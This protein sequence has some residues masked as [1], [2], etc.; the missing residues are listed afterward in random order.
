MSHIPYFDPEDVISH[1]VVEQPEAVN[2]R[3]AARRIVLQVLYE[4]DST[5]HPVG[6]VIDSQLIYHSLPQRMWTYIQEMVVGILEHHER[7]DRVIQHFAP[8][9]PL[10]Q[11]A[12]IDRNILRIAIYEFA[13]VKRTPVK[14][15]IDEAVRLAKLFGA[16]GSSRFVNGVLGAVVDDHE[17]LKTMLE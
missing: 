16:E 1:E 9:W 6:S 11:V 2:E 12:I 8:E 3:S 17:T 10:S 4:V 14:V 7:L 5:S 15:A 13:I